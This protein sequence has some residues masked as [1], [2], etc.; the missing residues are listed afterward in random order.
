MAA[1]RDAHYLRR[2][3]D[4]GY[5]HFAWNQPVLRQFPIH[6]IA[7]D[8]IEYFSHRDIA[9]GDSTPGVSSQVYDGA[10]Q[11]PV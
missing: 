2:L 8:S 5:L 9:Q 4:N 3:A 11:G 1:N 7:A 6:T 10:A